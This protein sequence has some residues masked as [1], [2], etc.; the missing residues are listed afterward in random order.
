MHFDEMSALH[1]GQAMK[2][3]RECEPRDSQLGTQLGELS[4]EVERLSGPA[5]QRLEFLVS[6]LK[7]GHLEQA[8]A[9]CFDSSRLFIC[10]HVTHY[11][12]RP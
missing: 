3:L 8:M 1:R 7:L 12:L 5:A 10:S 6:L 4:C 11:T 2:C 9:D